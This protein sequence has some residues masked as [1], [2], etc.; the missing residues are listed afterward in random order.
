MIGGVAAVWKMR[1]GLVA[2]A[3]AAVVIT[4]L[5]GPPAAAAQTACWQKVLDAWSKG[6][7]QATYP[8][9]CCRAALQHLP[10]GVRAY[11]T[12]TDDIQRALVAAIGRSGSS[13]KRTLASEHA[14]AA[15]TRSLGEGVQ[16]MNQTRLPA[17]PLLVLGGCVV[18]ALGAAVALAGPARKSPS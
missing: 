8:V 10:A 13:G 2:G 14:S 12:A 17:L 4:A 1:L 5:A 16:G 18:L 6:T 11:S 3:L 7:L 9:S 15:A